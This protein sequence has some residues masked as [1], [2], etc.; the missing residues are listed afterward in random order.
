MLP[1]CS[2]WALWSMVGPLGPQRALKT[3]LEP[4]LGPLGPMGPYAA[5]CGPHGALLRDVACLL[6]FR[7]GAEKTGPI[8]MGRLGG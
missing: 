7:L 5:V 2:V 3:P 4:P 8:G 6:S 1:I